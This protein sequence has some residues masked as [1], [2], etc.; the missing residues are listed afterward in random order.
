MEIL[1]S[2][3]EQWS[4]I[5]RHALGSIRV[6]YR[7]L[8]VD[9]DIYNA[10]DYLFTHDTIV[11]SCAVEDDGYTIRPACWDL[12]NDNGNAWTNEVLK[13]SY[14]TFIGGENYHE[15]VQAPTHSMGKILD[16]ILREVEHRGEQ[17]YVVDILVATS[18]RRCPSLVE[19]IERGDLKTMSMGASATH[20]QCSVCGRVFDTTKNEKFCTHLENDLGKEVE[21]NGQKKICAELCGAI[22]PKTKA[23]IP[24]SCTFIEASWVEKPA[25]E[26]AV[27]NYLIE[28]PEM[29]AERREKAEMEQV[30]TKVFLPSLRVADHVG[31]LALRLEAELEREE[32][33][34]RIAREIAR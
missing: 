3:R 5:R 21:Y 1:N 14:K 10:Q 11:A 9:W 8:D 2:P 18:R 30:F 13:N 16:A 23:Y 33:M 17:I 12:V 34:V 32:R 25:Y 6:A 22:D 24:G 19:R 4:S 20:V 27:T 7:E 15:H 31:K 29:K 26:G 28:T